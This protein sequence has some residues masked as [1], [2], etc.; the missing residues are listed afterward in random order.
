M[1]ITVELVPALPGDAPRIAGLHAASWRATYR[2]LIPDAFLDGKA[3]TERLAT[4]EARLRG[5]EGPLDVTLALVDGEAAGFACLMPRAEPERGV[6]LDNLHVLPA[7]HGLGLGKRLLAR[8]AQRAHAGEPGRPLFLYVLEGNA[9][10][11]EFY[12]RVGGTE[13]EPFEDAFAPA[14]MMVTV[15][16]V[17]WPDVPALLA[18]LG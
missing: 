10:A 14:D 4:W 6:Y 7:F 17:V 15:R 5:E 13:S 3:A 11:R 2:G 18:R 12:R 9:Q 16:R 1:P 8:C